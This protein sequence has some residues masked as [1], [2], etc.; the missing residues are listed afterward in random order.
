MYR[1]INVFAKLVYRILAFSGV[2][3]N[4]ESLLSDTSVG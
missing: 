3:T 2:F 4:F 1:K